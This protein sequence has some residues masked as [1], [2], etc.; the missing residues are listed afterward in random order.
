M[1]AR[2]LFGRRIDLDALWGVATTA[3]VTS[4]DGDVWASA[5]VDRGRRRTLV[6]AGAAL[7][8]LR[9]LRVR[10]TVQVHAVPAERHAPEPTLMD[11]A[12]ELRVELE[13]GAVLHV[14]PHRAGGTA[15]V[16]FADTPSRC[17]VIDLDDVASAATTLLTVTA[18]RLGDAA[19]AAAHDLDASAVHMVP[20]R[21]TQW[22]LSVV[23]DGGVVT[24]E[25]N[26]TVVDDA[27][28]GPA[29][30]VQVASTATLAR[31]AA[32]L[33]RDAAALLAA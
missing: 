15:A 33:T 32:D 13:D 19:W 11:A 7:R 28:R 3:P 17:W 5:A 26:G 8:L 29:G 16:F 22:R 20:A 30:A 10:G 27:R 4:I 2:T 23:T 31:A 6:G 24:A 9:V 14:L 12:V 21:H 1:A 25:P 18:E